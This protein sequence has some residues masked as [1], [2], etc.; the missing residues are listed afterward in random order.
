D[1]PPREGVE[2]L[3]FPFQ[4]VRPLDPQ[5]RAEEALLAAALNLRSGLDEPQA[6]SPYDRLLEGV[7]LFVDGARHTAD[8]RGNWE[9]YEPEELRAHSPLP[10]AR[11]IHVAGERRAWQ[12]RGV[13]RVEVVA[14][15]ARPH[16]R[17]RVQID[18]GVAGVQVLRLERAEHGRE[19]VA[20]L[21]ALVI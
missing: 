11:K 1:P 7:D 16:E 13:T 8:A 19:T 6:R 17:V 5:Q 21:G 9:R 2:A 18:R 15:P 20:F 4:C 12:R 3:D 10:H 14:D